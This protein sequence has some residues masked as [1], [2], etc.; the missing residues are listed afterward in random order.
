MRVLVVLVAGNRLIISH[1]DA[2]LGGRLP[3]YFR[4]IIALH[5]TWNYVPS[6]SLLQIWRYR[7]PCLGDC[8]FC[9]LPPLQATLHW[10]SMMWHEVIQWPGLMARHLVFV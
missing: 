10:S 4:C 7:G 3:I 2:A 1:S 9:S 8:N 6:S 5:H